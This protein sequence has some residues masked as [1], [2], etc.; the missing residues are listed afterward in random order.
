MS[1]GRMAPFAGRTVQFEELREGPLI[2]MQ[3]GAG[4]R[5][6]IEDS[7]RRAQ[8]RLKALSV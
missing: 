5:Q 2:L 6:M 1:R 4:V 7:L 3:E 8:K